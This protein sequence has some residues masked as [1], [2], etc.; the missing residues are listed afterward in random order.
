[1]RPGI[2]TPGLFLY[3]RY[4]YRTCLEALLE[5]GGAVAWERPPPNLKGGMMMRLLWA[6]AAI[7]TAMPAYASD[8]MTVRD[9]QTLCSGRQPGEA[10]R[11][12]ILGVVEG[13][14]VGAGIAKDNKHFCV[15]E[16]LTQTEMVAVV[17]RLSTADLAKYPSDAALPAVSV[18]VASLVHNYPCR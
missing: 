8:Q 12:Y 1:M 14:T 3:K 16:G 7:L 6:A 15:P 9:L 4:C 17:K 2:P 18:I 5:R 13:S 10:C 11:F